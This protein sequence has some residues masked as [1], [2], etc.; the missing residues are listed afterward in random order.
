MLKNRKFILIIFIALFLFLIPNIAKAEEVVIGVSRNKYASDG[1]TKYTF[2]GLELDTTKE[3]EFALT[4]TAAEE[5]T[6]WFDIT[7]YTATSAT[8]NVT[9]QTEKLRDIVKKVDTGYVT[10]R[11]KS[12][13]EIV[14]EDYA[15]D[16]ST[17]YLQV[18]S[19]AV[20]KNGKEFKTGR[21]EC[22]ELYLRNPNDGTPY[23]QYEKITDENVINKFKEIKNSNGDYYS[24]QSILKTTPPTAGWKEWLYFNGHGAITGYGYPERKI[25]IS[26]SGLYYLWIYFSGDTIK[27]LYGYILIDNL[28]DEIALDSISLP[29]TQ[30]V[31]LDKVLTLTPVFSP[32]NTTN[33]I[34][35]WTSSDETVAT[36][37]NAG[38]VTPKS[39]GSTIITVTSKDGSK[40]ATCTVTVVAPKTTPNETPN[41]TPN[42]TQNDEPTGVSDD[43]LTKLNALPNGGKIA[44]ISF[45]G[46]IIVS[47]I[48]AYIRYKKIYK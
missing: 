36:V 29:V 46:I 48:V 32:T 10:I 6:D 25:N 33:K 40:K 45:I 43:T 2:T 9:V 27:P 11:N 31:D 22:I 4:K 34:V 21:E 41:E 14:F 7:E 38:K 13:Q 35:T 37:D 23:Y 1:S 18:S 20:I 24:L 8:I 3:Y 39:I 17:P 47:T 5:I 42:G 26:D 44:L 19:Y 28:E 16:L 30:T 12:S 15:I